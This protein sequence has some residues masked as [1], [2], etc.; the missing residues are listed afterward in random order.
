MHYFL[1]LLL[2]LISIRTP[3][4]TLSKKNRSSSKSSLVEDETLIYNQQSERSQIWLIM[5][6]TNNF[7]DAVWGTFAEKSQK[8]LTAPAWPVLQI[9]SDVSSENDDVLKAGLKPVLW[10][11]SQTNQLQNIP[12][13][14]RAW[15][16]YW[17]LMEGE[18]SPALPSHRP[19]H[20]H[21]LT[22]GRKR[23]S[24]WRIKPGHASHSRAECLRVESLWSVAWSAERVTSVY[25]VSSARVQPEL[26]SFTSLQYWCWTWS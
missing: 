22:A 14:P 25:E 19:L 11:I 24:S 15:Q 3:L 5:F 26:P 13:V 21:A 20:K 17:A 2:S 7:S 4:F 9:S 16:L 10:L 18:Q 1:C 23:S 6:D 12:R 8:G